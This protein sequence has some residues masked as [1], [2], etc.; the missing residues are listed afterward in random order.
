M[1][2]KPGMAGSPLFCL[3]ITVLLGVLGGWVF[4]KGRVSSCVLVVISLAAGFYWCSKFYDYPPTEISAEQFRH[5]MTV[6]ESSPEQLTALNLI[7]VSKCYH[8][9]YGWLDSMTD[10]Y[11]FEASPDT[12]RCLTQHLSLHEFMLRPDKT[13][14][15]IFGDKFFF[16]EPPYWWRP[17]QLKTTNIFYWPIGG[18]PNPRIILVYDEN[19]HLGYL[20]LGCVPSEPHR[21][22][23]EHPNE[24]PPR[25]KSD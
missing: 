25:F 7:V 24:T 1:D 22:K 3:S 21:R 11:R 12:I 9:F 17:D 8:Y 23:A 5:N 18:W 10:L 13:L 6:T 4:K 16:S 19:S 14:G 2:P 15:D 20:S